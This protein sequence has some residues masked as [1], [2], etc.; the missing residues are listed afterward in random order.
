MTHNSGNTM[1]APTL[2]SEKKEASTTQKM[3]TPR[4]CAGSVQNVLYVPA[5][6]DGSS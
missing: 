6:G 2:P 4:S 3:T 5:G 1:A